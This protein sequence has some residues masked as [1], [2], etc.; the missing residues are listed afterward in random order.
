MSENYQTNNIKIKEYF[1]KIKYTQDFKNDLIQK[2]K[3]IESLDA[4]IFEYQQQTIQEHDW[5]NEWKNYF[6]PFRASA[7]FTIVPSWETYQKKTKMKCVL[8]WIQVWLLVQ[9]IIQRQVCA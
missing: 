5:E 6:H 9:V 8:S 3:N 7:K 2:I 4:K 1:N